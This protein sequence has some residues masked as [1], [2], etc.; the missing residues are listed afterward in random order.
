[1][2]LVLAVLFIPCG[3]TDGITD[4]FTDAAKRLSHATVVGVT[5]E[6]SYSYKNLKQ[7]LKNS[8]SKQ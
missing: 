4:S 6:Y 5:R 2:I 7:E 3:Q 1:M 8:K